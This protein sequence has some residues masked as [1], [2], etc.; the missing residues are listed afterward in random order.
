MKRSLTVLGATALTAALLVPQPAHALTP[1]QADSAFDDFV[2]DFWDDSANYF[3]TYSDHQIH[4]EHAHGPH[5]GLYTDYWWEAQLWET[6]MDVYERTGDVDARQMIDDIYDGFQTQYPDFRDNDWNDDIGWWARGAIRAYE[7]TGDV[8]YRDDAIE[9]FDFIAQYADTTYGGGIWW[10]NVDIGDGERNEK[11]VATNAT[12]VYTAMRI[13]AATGDVSYRD[14]ARSL[15]AWLDANFYVGGKLRDHIEGTGQ[16][17]DWD[18]TYNQGNYAGAALEMY[19]DSGDPAE[20]SRAVAAIDWA[21]ANL[22]SSGTFLFE[23]VDDTGGFKAILT[24]NIR[25]LIDDAGQTQY[26]QLLTDNATQ[27]ANHLNSAGIG[28]YDWTAPAP[29]LGTTAIQSLAAAASVAVMHQATP[30]GYTG[31]VEGTRVYEAEN[32]ERSGVISESGQ[33]GYSGRG[34]IG[35]WIGDGTGVTFHVNVAAA[36]SYE[37]QFHYAAA[38]GVASRALTVNGATTPLSFPAT[39]GWGDWQART[40][41]VSLAAGYNRVDLR[42]DSAAGSTNYLNLDRM[43]V[44]D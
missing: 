41:T 28:A 4:P 35:G 25:A 7:I 32:T 43:T 40:V 42:V 34:Y 39:S 20:L 44:A 15:F 30:D 38:G 13:Y 36:G 5:G 1:P 6:V 12:A 26:E 8:E 27:A 31:P 21:T 29:E 19:L 10:K 2:D 24:R 23:G 16:F 18:W 37:L 3:F 9:M 14:T 11:N 22:T 33:S 17:V